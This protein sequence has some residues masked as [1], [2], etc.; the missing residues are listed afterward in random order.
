MISTIYSFILVLLI[1]EL[2]S[3]NLLHTFALA[4]SVS[5]RISIVT[6]ANGYVGREIVHTLLADEDRKNQRIYCLV[7]EQRVE[8]ETNY[9]TDRS[10]CVTV[11][12]YDMLDGGESV[13]NVLKSEFESSDDYDGTLSPC[14]YHVASVFGPSQDHIQT[15][16]DN[17]KGTEDL[18]RVLAEFKNCRLVVTSSMAAVRGSGQVP[19]NGKF[20]TFQDWNTLSQLGANWGS[21]YQWSKMESERRAW[22]LTREYNIPMSSI[23]PSFVF[24]P[25]SDGMMT[26]SYSITMVS[27]WVR[28][29]SPVQSRLCVDI[30]DV[31]QAHVAAGTLPQAIG[32]RFIVSKE[33]RVPS[34][35]MAEALRQ[36]CRDLGL[37]NPDAINF[38]AD[39][40][41]GAI[42]I[43]SR[44]V[45]SVERLN[46][47]LGITLRPVF[48][49]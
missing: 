19:T 4:N 26:S 20:Y 44:E 32:Q 16:K 24:G 41:G 21:S 1:L 33:E 48:E 39:F 8:S 40:Q 49:T 9:W 45:E 46:D 30:R 15:A 23:C 3:K 31:A 11:M 12:P 6:G 18:I 38:D 25:P 35:E 5:P 43:G 29:E 42:P 13:R 34:K 27:Q 37:G 36:V 10:N 7:R 2:N 17:V 22:E 14:I 47:S 28:G